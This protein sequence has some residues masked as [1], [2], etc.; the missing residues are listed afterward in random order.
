V[1]EPDHIETALNIPIDTKT[2]PKHSKAKAKI[3][4]LYEQEI[5]PHD[6]IA[7]II[8]YDTGKKPQ[9]KHLVKL[10]KGKGYLDVVNVGPYS[11]AL[12]IMQKAAMG[13][14]YPGY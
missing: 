12:I 5:L 9:A 7:P 14:D 10:L 4:S 8:V 1:F 2:D 6:R 11:T 3:D 13:D